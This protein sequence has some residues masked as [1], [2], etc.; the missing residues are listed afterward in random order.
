M[1][2]KNSAQGLMNPENA[3]RLVMELQMEANQQI[4]TK[5]TEKMVTACFER[6]A[7]TSV[8]KSCLLV[9]VG[10]VFCVA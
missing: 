4:M 5:M 3:R 1:D 2:N 10:S 7:G 8:S 6:C 9:P